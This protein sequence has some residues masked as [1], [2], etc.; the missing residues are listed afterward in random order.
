MLEAY[1][2][3]LDKNGQLREFLGRA[4]TA[5]EKNPGDLDATA[6][7]F[8]YY[9]HA[10]NL[11]EARR[12]LLEY[13][14]AKEAKPGSWTPAELRTLAGLFA[15]LP[16]ANEEARAFYA[17]YSAPG[18]AAA[19]R[20]TALAGMIALLL[21]KPEEPI[22]FGS[23]DLSLY[24]DI[25]AADSSPGFLNGLLSL[26]LNST[27]PRWQ[28]QQQNAAALAYFHRAEGAQ[29]LGELEKQFPMSSHRA[30]LRS[31]LID[32]YASYGDDDAAIMAARAFLSGFPKAAERTHVAL[33]LADA[34]ARQQRT[35]EEFS[36]YEHM[37][38]ELAAAAEGVP[39]GTYG[40]SDKGLVEPQG[41]VLPAG[42][43]EQTRV[44]PGPRSTDYAEV[45][46]KYLARLSALGQP[47]E[48][49]RVYRRELDRNPKDPG[50]YERFAGFLEQNNLGAD[51]QDVY[52]RAIAKFPGDFWY[53]KLARWYLRGQTNRRLHRADT[54]SHRHL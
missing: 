29:L 2:Q 4:R 31:S 36:V 3:L 43:P 23:G 32:A 46:D 39:L 45:L 34:L 33:A 41:N 7:L 53:D 28:Y 35:Q 40:G 17:L 16:D 51:V 49:L 15:R 9:Q 10:N 8:A 50:L 47:M 13:R 14:L 38:A 26:V 30:A 1:F 52:R 42:A 22:R 5:R 27:S 11:G 37:L 19:D 18:A 44:A 48:A 24:K 25:G 12:T 21:D 6:R 20:E 54:R